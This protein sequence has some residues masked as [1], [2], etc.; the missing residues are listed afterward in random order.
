MHI[1]KITQNQQDKTKT[2]QKCHIWSQKI[3]WTNTVLV[4]QSKNT[5]FTLQH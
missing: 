1:Q 2:V 3:M 4:S 5:I